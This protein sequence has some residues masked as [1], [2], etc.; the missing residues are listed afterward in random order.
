MALHTSPAGFSSAWPLFIEPLVI[1]AVFLFS[2]PLIFVPFVIWWDATRL[3]MY[4][5]MAW[6]LALPVALLGGVVLP[7]AGLGVPG[8]GL[9]AWLLV[10]CLY[11]VVRHQPDER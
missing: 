8:L 1:V 3:G 9:G 7:N 10:L 4:R 5:P 2:V 11:V 6:A